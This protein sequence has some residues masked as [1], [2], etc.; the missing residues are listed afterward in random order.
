[1]SGNKGRISNRVFLLVCFFAFIKTNAFGNFSRTKAKIESLKSSVQK[2]NRMVDSTNSQ[3]SKIID[4]KNQLFADIDSVEEQIEL[5]DHSLNNELKKFK[6]VLLRYEALDYSVDEN[7]A[8]LL[9]VRNLKF[10]KKLFSTEKLNS[11]NF[12][13][14]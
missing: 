5:T 7:E 9:T 10:R 14:I 6:K 3:F 8:K 2:F 11:R 12:A 1:M 4:L 13:R